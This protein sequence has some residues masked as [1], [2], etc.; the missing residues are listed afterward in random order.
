MATESAIKPAIRRVVTG[1]DERGRSK[2]LWDSPAPNSRSMDGSAAS[3]LSDIWVWAESPAPLYGERDDGNMK[4][5]FPGPPEGGH[6][7]VIRSSGRPENYDPAK[8]QNAVA[9]HDPKP[10]PSGRTWDRGGRNAFT[11]DMHKTQSIDYAIELVGE[12]DLGMDDGNHTIRQGDIVVQVG[13]WHQWIRN[14]AAGSTMMYDM[15]AAKFTDGPQGIAQGNDAVMTF[16]GRAL[17]PGA[18]TA[19][20]VVTIDRVPN[21]GSVIAD[22]P[23]PDVRTDPARPGFM[24]SRLWVTDGSPAKI[25]NET[26]HLPHAIEPPEKGSVLRVYNFPPDKAW[27]GRVGRADVDAYFKA[28]GSPAASTWSAQA[29]HP[30][31]QKTRT[32]DICAV[33]EGEIAL[34]LDTREVKLAAGD[35]VVQRGTNH[36]WSN[37]S[38]KPAVV[39]VAS[40]D[41][42]YAP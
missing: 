25:V 14:N 5:D 7:R 15:F 19:R 16:D 32:L 42:K 34:V 22:G 10:L 41:G 8:D 28:M 29:P 11:T 27:Q 31:M 13:A 33:L 35:V 24:V 23:A 9:M 39:S 38:D 30:Y 2:V 3:L 17:P 4:Y 18:K 36:A 20:R 12:R 21:K 40:H 6:V 26:L 37:R 1:I